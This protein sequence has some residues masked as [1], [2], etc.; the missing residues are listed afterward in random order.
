MDNRWI[1]VSVKGPLDVKDV[2]ISLLIEAGSPGVVEDDHQDGKTASCTAFIPEGFLENLPSL[3][4]R[5]RRL[6]C[7]IRTSPYKE[8]DWSERWKRFVRPVRIEDRIIVKPSWYRMDDAPGR[9][10]VNIDP[11]MAFG[12]GNHPSTR[13]ALKAM[14]VA[15]RKYR[16]RSMLDVGTGSGIL[17]IVA[18]KMGI[19]YI[20]AIDV[21]TTALR[22]ARKNA[23]LNNVD[24]RFSRKR[25]E[26]IRER[27][28]LVVANIL[29][30]E[31][32]NISTPL[33]ERVERRGTLILSG[34]LCNEL[35]VIKRVYTGRGMKYFKT[36]R[37]GE[38]ACPVFKRG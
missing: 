10:L 14:V 32:I 17:A 5:L 9:I 1:K 25:V 6:N 38:W 22:I 37:S 24:V 8:T 27:F 33:A 29:C 35:D 7:R 12:T 11:G 13:L 31:L 23:L 2:V 20:T 36:Y 30:E 4:E 16:Y 19:K 21:D 26:R 18:G 3:R 34:I 28:S 15:S